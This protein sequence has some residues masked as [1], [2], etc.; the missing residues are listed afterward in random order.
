MARA[1]GGPPTIAAATIAAMSPT[2]V[3]APPHTIRD[4]VRAA[5]LEAWRQ[6]AAAGQLPAGPDAPSTAGTTIDIERPANRDHGDIATNLALKLARPLRMAPAAIA[7]ALADAINALD[8]SR[9]AADAGPSP[10]AGAVVAGPGFINL[11]LTDPALAGLLDGARRDP[12]T[13]GRVP[14]GS[15]RAVNVE[16]VSA[17]PTGP[18]TVGNARGAFVGDLLCRV[19]EAAGQRVTR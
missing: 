10:V 8:G 2:D 13:W 11:R 12:A 1:G 5:I 16:F 9:A 19:L 14:A 4:A 18:L 3:P 15:G 17:N 6:A 7:G